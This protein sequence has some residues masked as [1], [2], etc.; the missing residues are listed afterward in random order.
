MYK[1]FYAWTDNNGNLTLTTYVSDDPADGHLTLVFDK[2]HAAEMVTGLS[3]AFEWAK[4][5][6]AKKEKAD[7]QPL[8]VV[9]S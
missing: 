1:T 3:N 6:A 5:L 7:A 4:D 8:S 2:E 9:A